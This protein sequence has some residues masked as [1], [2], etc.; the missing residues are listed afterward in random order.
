MVL[1]E[2]H[3][4]PISIASCVTDIGQDA[5]EMQNSEISVSH[6]ILQRD[7]VQN[8][9]LLHPPVLLDQPLT[10]L[11]PRRGFHS[12]SASVKMLLPRKGGWVPVHKSPPSGTGG[13]CYLFIFHLQREGVM[14]SISHVHYMGVSYSQ[15]ICCKYTLYF[16]NLATPWRHDPASGYSL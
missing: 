15:L 12:K 6:E 7:I 1:P 16:L 2:I 5:V 14:N 10:G 3:E 8:D 13:C 9:L 4:F 11:R